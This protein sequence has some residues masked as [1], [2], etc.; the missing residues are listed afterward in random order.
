MIEEEVTT[1]VLIDMTI[2]VEGESYLCMSIFHQALPFLTFWLTRVPCTSPYY[3]HPAVMVEAV[4][5]V[6]TLVRFINV[7]FGKPTLA[8]VRSTRWIVPS[9]PASKG[10]PA[11]LGGL[12][13]RSRS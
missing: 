8:L 1:E 5:A 10:G 3:L 2:A 7:S 13:S 11:P 12:V 6:A 9:W 4:E